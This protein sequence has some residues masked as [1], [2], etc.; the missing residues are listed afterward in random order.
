M[1][2]RP[3]QRVTSGGGRNTLIERFPLLRPFPMTVFAVGAM[4]LAVAALAVGAPARGGVS[5][6]ARRVA[7][8]PAAQSTPARA[9]A[10]PTVFQA[11]VVAP[12]DE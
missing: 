10:G 7:Q 8:A 3:S 9:A 12:D 6:Q 2:R 1:L 4:M 11:L 5:G